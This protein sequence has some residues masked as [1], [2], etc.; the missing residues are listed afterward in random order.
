MKMLEFHFS[1]KPTVQL[2]IEKTVKKMHQRYLALRRL[3]K[4]GMTQPELVAVYRSVVLPLAGYCSPAYHSMMTD[5][6]DELMEGAQTGALR[7]IYGYGISAR[8][9]RAESSLQT[10]RSRRIEQTDK[11][12]RKCQT[13][14]L[15]TGSP[16]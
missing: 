3:G 16:K 7:A 10:L 6:Q 4:F 15:L 5:Q 12:A 1:A 13:Q 14:D 8:R 9:L 11:F 2:H